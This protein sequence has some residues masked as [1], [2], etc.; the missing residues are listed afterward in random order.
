MKEIIR[1][2]IMMVLLIINTSIYSII[3]LNQQHIYA[4]REEKSKKVINLQTEYVD[5]IGKKEVCWK[6]C[7]TA[8]NENFIPK[9]II[10][11][12]INK[13]APIINLD[14][15]KINKHG[16]KGD[17][18]NFLDKQ[19]NEWVLNIHRNNREWFFIFW[20][21]SAKIESDFKYI[22]TKIPSLREGDIVS[23]ENHNTT[24]MYKF[25]KS[26]IITPDELDN[27]KN[28][29]DT[30]YLITCY[31]YLTS[32]KRFVVELQLEQNYIDAEI[33]KTKNIK[34]L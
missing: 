29:K 18:V 7:S 20:H 17:I 6:K 4:I 19:L 9:K 14:F 22:F 11:P 3:W 5:K 12:S 8:L 16:N 32:K 31:P 15:E 23:L 26:Y 30:L 10:L 1:L 21:S 33:S 27:L 28:E 34:S 24:K 25:D 13:T 2:Y